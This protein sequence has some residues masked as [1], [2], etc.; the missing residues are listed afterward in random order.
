MSGI[1]LAAAA[2]TVGLGLGACTGSPVASPDPAGA[3]PSANEPAAGTPVE[4]PD[5]YRNGDP[6]SA[7]MQ[8]DVPDALDDD[9]EA[10]AEYLADPPNLRVPDPWRAGDPLPGYLVPRSDLERN[11]IVTSSLRRVGAAEGVE[12]WEGTATD[13]GVCGLW[14]A[15]RGSI[16]MVNCE[17]EADFAENGIGLIGEQAYP[18]ESNPHR[19]MSVD[20]YLLPREARAKGMRVRGFH[21][22]AN[23]L[24]I[25]EKPAPTTSISVPVADGT[26]TFRVRI[27]G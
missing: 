13:G 26:R 11:G 20:A 25:R 4:T 1:A 6:S 10:L 9:S 2:L 22:V 14:V 18:S 24:F 5:E 12:I 7:E 15:I 3:P 16:Q 17:S 23:R 27:M 19:T 8:G 21:T